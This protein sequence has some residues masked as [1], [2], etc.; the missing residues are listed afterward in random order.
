M[1]RNDL[2]SQAIALLPSEEACR[3]AALKSESGTVEEG[4]TWP[5]LWPGGLR[6]AEELAELLPSDET[7]KRHKHL[8][9][10]GCGRGLLGM[11]AL[12]LSFQRVSFIDGDELP[13]KL[14]AKE[15][16]S[17]PQARCQLLE[18]G[19]SVPGDKADIL[20]GGDV[21]YRPEY[22]NS[23][24]RTIS[25]SLKPNGVAFLGDPRNKLEGHLPTIAEQNGLDCKIELR[26]GGYSLCSLKK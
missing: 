20:L 15:L 4:A 9:D 19:Q 2:I 11:A 1:Q 7:S 13:I 26:P 6:L 17:F 25:E 22:H 12:C 8:I 16:A 21:L 14:I 23:L 10:L 3:K 5:Y 24:L 18:W